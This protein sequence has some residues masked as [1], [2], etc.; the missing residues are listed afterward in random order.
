MNEGYALRHLRKVMNWS[1]EDDNRETI[2]LRMMSDFKYDSYRSFWAGSRFAEA[3]LYWFLLALP[4]CSTWRTVL[5][6]FTLAN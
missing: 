2:W 1:F 6:P 5:Y 4:K 3:L